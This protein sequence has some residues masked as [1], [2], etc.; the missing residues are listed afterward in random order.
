M[1]WVILIL[2]FP[3]FGGLFYL[4]IYSQQHSRRYLRQLEQQW[5]WL[6]VQLPE[7]TAAR[8]AWAAQYPQDTRTLHYLAQMGYRPCGGTQA[9]YLSP[10]EDWGRAMLED[11]RQARRYIYLEFFIL[12]DGQLWQEILSILRERAA[13]GVDVR[14][15]YDGLGSVNLPRTFPRQMADMG[16]RCKVFNPF[17]P[18]LTAV[19]NHRDHRKICVIDGRVAYTGGA[20]LSDEYVN[21]THPYGH[22]KDAMLR[23]QGDSMIDIGILDGD[24]VVLRRQDS[25]E[26]GDIVVALVGE[27]ATLKR[28][29]YE[30]GRVRLQPENRAMPPIYVDDAAV[31]GRL[32]AL[33]RQF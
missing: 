1:A 17:R 27:E 14:L 6:S 9:T 11:L 8:D 29:F 10:G 26:N 30:D 20:N 25:A 5:R 32:T 2:G 31:L 13:A 22:W 33:I 18:F 21:L 7:D 12:E 24:I 3:V 4:F 23:V 15:L 16:I 28:I 19:Q